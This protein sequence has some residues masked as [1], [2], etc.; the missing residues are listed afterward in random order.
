MSAVTAFA[1]AYPSAT[2][3]KIA[4]IN[5]QSARQRSW[6][7]FAG[8]PHRVG[9][10]ELI[11]EQESQAVQ[12]LSDFS[13]L[14]RL[15]MLAT[16]IAQAGLPPARR[17]LIQ[18]Q[19]AAIGHRFDEAR[20]YLAVAEDAGADTELIDRLASSI[21]QAC[22]VS[23]Y[24]LL[25]K[26]RRIA[27]EA[28][29]LEELLPLGALLV[30]LSEFDEAD[31]VFRRAL[32]AYSDVSPFA[33]AQV[34]FQL[35]ILWGETVSDPQTDVAAQWYRRAV[36][37]IPAYT[38]A[39]VH[40]AEILNSCGR[41]DEAGA[42]LTP[43]AGSSDPEVQWRLADI[44]FEKGDVAEAQA[45]LQA[46]CLRFEHLLQRYPL[47]FADHGAEFFAGSGN[48]PGRAVEL[49]RLN[50]AN[51]PTLRAFE[52]AHAIAVSTGNTAAASELLV[53]AGQRWG[54]T[55]A[56]RISSLARCA[57]ENFEGTTAR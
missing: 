10:A 52:F 12:F 36:G 40:L 2:D 11:V 39:R 48:N 31:E 1:T 47:A 22:G 20:R 21:D 27:T 25:D 46:A 5:L 42:L 51:R 37:Y 18:A 54:G 23:L 32:R 55:N 8:D 49:A 17:M 50:V 43:I 13:A 41:L 15:D 28:D 29:S 56:F 35:G 57:A 34:C 16:Q 9:V 45:Y 30:D 3:G 33:V 44:L 14:D 38:K 6:S 4:V 24:A 26:R 19:V 53:E 7:R